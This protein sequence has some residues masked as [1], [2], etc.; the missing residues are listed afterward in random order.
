MISAL[1][2][3]T[4]ATPSYSFWNRLLSRPRN[5]AF[6]SSLSAIHRGIHRSDPG[7]HRAR[8]RVRGERGRPTTSPNGRPANDAR[9]RSRNLTAKEVRDAIVNEDTESTAGRQSRRK[10]FHN[11]ESNFGKKSL[12]YRMKFGD[13]KDKATSILASNQKAHEEARVKATPRGQRRT[14]PSS[15]RTEAKS[16]WNKSTSE[17]SQT[18]IEGAR[19]EFEEDTKQRGP[20]KNKHPISVRYTTAASQ[21]LFGKSVVKA[22]LAM[23]KRKSYHLYI[24]EGEKRQQDYE[25]L[26]SLVKAKRIPVTVVKDAGKALMDKMSGGRPHNG[27]VLE[28]SPL[29]QIPV[30]SLG[31]LIGNPWKPAFAVTLG[32]Q[33]AEEE[34][35]NGTDS[36]LY[37]Q[38]RKLQKPLVLLLN[39]VLDPGNMGALLR[40]A[41]FLGVSAVAITRHGSASLTP[42]VLKAS[43][44]AA[45]EIPLVTVDSAIDFISGSKAAGWRIYAAAP[46]TSRKDARKITLDQVEEQN[47]LSAAPCVLVLGS[48]GQGLPWALRR[49]A[50]YEVSIPGTTS[51][52]S[53]DSLN[54]S[55]AGGVL[56]NAF[57]RIRQPKKEDPAPVNV[58]GDAQMEQDGSSAEK[59]ESAKRVEEEGLF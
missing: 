37:Y 29:P 58:S 34:A 27:Y 21:F 49:E 43:A 8:G 4:Q 57:L 54:V 59:R 48:E 32:R 6:A 22:A 2:L 56:C 9:D 38:N 23:G 14:E 41:R 40:T 24:L 15:Q 18:N 28:A 50:D 11:P 17:K 33:S 42:V 31:P 5:A 46:L 52:T 12:V 7:A 25:S 30:S 16:R 39:E 45:E 44:G 1:R 26:R 55:V 19:H 13:L 35:I 36:V 20:K 10:R 51:N 3:T 53:V 47:P